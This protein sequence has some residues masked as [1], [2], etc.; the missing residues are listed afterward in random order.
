MKAIK[1]IFILTLAIVIN[2]CSNPRESVSQ[3]SQG[4]PVETKKPNADYK[5]AFEGQTRAP[6]IKTSAAYQA[7]VIAEGIGSPWG[8]AH[9]P[10]GRLLVTDKSGF[11]QIF[12]TEGA[13]LGKV[14]GFPAVVD[15]GQGGMLGV[16]FDPDF[17]SNRMIYWVFSEPYKDGN[18]TS[19]AKG[20]LSDDDSSIENPQVIFRAA[21]EYNGRL[22][23]GGRI[24]FDNDGYL[25]VGTGER[26]DLATRPLA[27]DISTGLGKV[28]RM[29]KDGNPAPGNPLLNNAEAMPQIYS[30]GHRNVQGLAIDPQTGELWN[31]EFGPRGGDEINLVKPGKNYG[32]AVITYGIEYSGKKVGEGIT[33][34]EGMEQPNY[35]WDPSPSPSGMTFYTGEIEEWKNNLFIGCLSGQH[36][37]RLIIDG[38]RILGEERLLESEGERFRDVHQGADG[39]LYAVTDSG[40]IYRI[41]K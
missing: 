12:S 1:F 41:G 30:W 2:G 34:K 9:F 17:S 15:R 6:G 28:L 22:H 8:L 24:I 19:V 38:D 31:S 29:D 3:T 16:T 36:I 13:L 39:K 40:K 4:E 33:Q 35:Y 11:M 14:T 27:Q 21:P 37:I 5:P 25:F 32:W 26:S 7:D 18:L 20:R 23:F 10:D